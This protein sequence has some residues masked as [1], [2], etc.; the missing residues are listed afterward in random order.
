MT[1]PRE[2]FEQTVLSFFDPIRKLLDD[3]TVSEVMINGFD[4]IWVER[5]GKV[6]RTDASFANLEALTS[7]IRNLAQFVGRHVD[8]HRPILEARLPDGSRVE[9]IL[10][11]ASPDG[12]SVAIRRFF[13]ETLT[14]ERLINF[15]SLTGDAAGCLQALV[16]AKNNVIVAGGTGS[17]KTSLLN[18]LSSFIADDER[19]VVIEDSRELQLQKPH[20][21][22]LE[23]RPPDAKGRGKVSIR[24]LFK[25]TLRMRP[26]RIV[27][28]EIRSG[29]ALDLV[30]AMTS[31]HGGAL[32]TVHATYPID[33]MN[34]LETMAMM[35]D[36]EIPLYAL[37]AQVGSA[38]DIVV[39]TSRLQDGS[40]CITHITQVVGYD[41]EKGYILEDLFLRRYT[42]REP[43]G[44]VLSDF[45]PT[46]NLPRSLE[47]IRAMGMELPPSMYDAHERLK[48]GHRV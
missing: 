16:A 24:D 47:M 41:S 13:R 40:R 28:G 4:E 27:V 3:P 35:S 22:M 30:Q 8:E 48:A 43:D 39:Q 9:A 1:I 46:G 45:R 18:V 2:V 21:V 29:E 17:G 23:A 10:P 25:A 26:D 36:V 7:A 5:K 20:V 14:I 6:H 32:C 37:R 12:P 42:G 38:V 33:T 15:G 19:I 34:R 11:P 44:R 31:G